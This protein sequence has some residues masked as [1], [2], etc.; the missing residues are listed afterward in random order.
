[1]FYYIIN[2]EVLKV[3]NSKKTKNNTQEKKFIKTKQKVNGGIEVELQKNPS[4]TKI[5]KFFAVLIA[6]LTVGVSLISL[7]YLM[8]LLIQRMY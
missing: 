1:M 3:K 6:V 2:I 5:G 7:I 8:V 4:E